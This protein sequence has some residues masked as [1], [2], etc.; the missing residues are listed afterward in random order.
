MATTPRANAKAPAYPIGSVENALRL[1]RMLR[2]RPSIR[3]AEAADELSV[4]RS[5]AHRLLA[6]LQ[7]YELV[8]QDPESRAYRPGPLLAELGLATLRHDD[9]LTMLHPFLE[10]L[11]STLNETAHLI[12]L[13]GPNCRF[14]D[15]IESKHALRTTARIGVVYPAYLTSGGKVLLAELADDELRRLYPQRRLP[16]LTDRSPASRKQLLEE[17]ERIRAAG[18]ATNFGES[19]L[20]IHA[21]AMVVRTSAGRP[22]AAMAVSAPEQRLPESRVPELVEALTDVTARAR[23]RLR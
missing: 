20:G 16:Q 1:L 21:V 13:E 12:V 7:A 11:S 23:P 6:M 2:D 10:E 15:S 17:L 22:A 5:T 19:E 8:T 4:A 14:V 9:M 18:Y 3:V